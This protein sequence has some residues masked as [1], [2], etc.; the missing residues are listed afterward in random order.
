MGG[1]AGGGRSKNCDFSFIGMLDVLSFGKNRVLVMYVKNF[2]DQTR[3][4]VT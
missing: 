1:G 3:L 4:E 2:V